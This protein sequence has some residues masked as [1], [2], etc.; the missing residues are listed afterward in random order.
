M[1]FHPRGWCCSGGTVCLASRIA[2]IFVAAELR[3]DVSSPARKLRS[4]SGTWTRTVFAEVLCQQVACPSPTL[5]NASRSRWPSARRHTL[6]ATVQGK[7]QLKVC[8]SA[9]MPVFSF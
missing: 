9:G 1:K 5:Q 2:R 8:F 6:A 4:F 3:K 7:N